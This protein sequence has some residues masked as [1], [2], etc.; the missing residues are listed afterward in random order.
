MPNKNA[1]D[2]I[3]G[4]ETC[5]VIAFSTNLRYYKNAIDPIEGIETMPQHQPQPLH[6]PQP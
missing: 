5:L 6:Q 1:I 4:I 2:P 3:E